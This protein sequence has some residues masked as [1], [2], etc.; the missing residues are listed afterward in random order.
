MNSFYD[1]L[2]EAF[3]SKFDTD[4]NFSVEKKEN[5]TLIT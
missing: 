5:Y 4:A 3:C 1:G 2:T